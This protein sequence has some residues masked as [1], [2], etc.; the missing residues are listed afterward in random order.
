SLPCP[1]LQYLSIS[2]YY[3]CTSHLLP[4]FFFFFFN[5]PA[6]TEIYTLSLHDALPIS[7]LLLATS[8]A[9]S[10]PCSMIADTRWKKLRHPPLSRFSAWKGF[11]NLEISSW[12]LRIVTE[13]VAFQIIESKSFAKLRWLRALAFRSKAWPSR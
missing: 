10:A 13:R 12:L 3:L 1:T 11:R 6:T 9:K 2:T 4:I 7:I 5:A 8:M